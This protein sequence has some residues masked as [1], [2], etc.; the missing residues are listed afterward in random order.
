MITDARLRWLSGHD[1]PDYLNS[2]P[3]QIAGELLQARARI[4][5]LSQQRPASLRQRVVELDAALRKIVFEGTVY[6]CH[7]QLEHCAQAMYDIAEAAVAT[8]ETS[9]SS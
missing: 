7:H 5:E 3:G 2:E 9:E 8:L 1:C 4:T 6:A